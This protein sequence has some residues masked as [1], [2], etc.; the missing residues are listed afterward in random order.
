VPEADI[1][2]T[3]LNKQKDRLAAVFRKSDAIAFYP[4]V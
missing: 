1:A 2:E 4:L 3:E